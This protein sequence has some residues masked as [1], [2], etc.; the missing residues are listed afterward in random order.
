MS[1]DSPLLARNV[2]VQSGKRAPL[3]KIPF[4]HL[5]K[6]CHEQYTIE[7]VRHVN[8]APEVY[9]AQLSASQSQC[10]SDPK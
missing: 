6:N 1:L 8:G 10:P 7:D 2:F 4:C 3:L 9:H 5:S